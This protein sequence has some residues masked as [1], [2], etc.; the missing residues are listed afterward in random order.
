MW[1][2]EVDSE[3]GF[4]GWHAHDWGVVSCGMAWVALGDVFG[5]IGVL[6]SLGGLLSMRRG[7]KAVMSRLSGGAFIITVLMIL[8]PFK[9]GLQ[10]RLISLGVLE[11]SG[12]YCIGW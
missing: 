5:G 12:L 10:W 3:F 7:G 2:I 6:W 9:A 1:T 4:A 8:S 11:V